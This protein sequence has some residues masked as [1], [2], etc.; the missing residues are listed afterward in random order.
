M[1]EHNKFWEGGRPRDICILTSESLFKPPEAHYIYGSIADTIRY[2]YENSF[3]YFLN[4]LAIDQVLRAHIGLAIK[5]RSK[6]DDYNIDSKS[7]LENKRKQYSSIYDAK[8]VV[9]GDHYDFLR[10]RQELEYITS[11]EVEWQLYGEAPTFK[12]L[13]NQHKQPDFVRSLV[14]DMR[15]LASLLDGFFALLNS[16]YSTLFESVSSLSNFAVA[17]S[18]YRYQKQLSILTWALIILTVVMVVLTVVMVVP[19]ITRFMT[20]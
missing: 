9:S 2:E 18:T 15:H 8:N 6:L 3:N 20:Q 10:F 19:V 17:D 4:L 12:L 7:S 14:S 16:R 11:A 13:D 1:F 5:H